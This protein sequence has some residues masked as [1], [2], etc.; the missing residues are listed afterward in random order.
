MRRYCTVAV[1]I[2]FALM[3]PAAAHAEVFT[4]A[5]PTE[6]ALADAVDAANDREGADTVLLNGYTIMLAEDHVNVIDELTLRGP[7]TLDGSG[8]ESD[9]I[10]EAWADLTIDDVR[11]VNNDD[12]R[13]LLVLAPADVRV[14]RSTFTGNDGAIGVY[15]SELTVAAR[16]AQQLA[17]GSLVVTD[18]TFE[19]NVEQYGGAIDIDPGQSTNV[20]VTVARSTF[21]G[22]R[23]VSEGDAARRRDQHL[24]RHARRRELDLLGQLRR[25]AE[26]R[27]RRRRDR[28]QR[29]R[30]GDAHPRH[31]HGQPRRV[32]RPRRRH[33]RPAVRRLRGAV[34]RA[35][36][37]GQLDRGRQHVR[38]H[39]GGALRRRAGGAGRRLRLRGR[40]AGRQPG[41]RHHL[42]LPRRDR[43]AERRP[44][45]RGAGRQ[46]RAD[47][48]ARARRRLA[49]R[50]HG[51]RR[52]MPVHRPARHGARRH[53]L[54][55]RRLRARA[56]GHAAVRAGGRG[57]RRGGAQR[58]PERPALQDPPAGAARRG[59][60]QGDREGQRQARE[61]EA[62]QAADRGRRPAR[63]HE[64]ALQGQH[65]A[66]PEGRRQGH[67]RPP[68]LDV[69]AGDPL[70]QAAE[71]LRIQF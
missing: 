60:A 66:A 26:L 52:P 70:D 31:D 40:H 1:A 20:Q 12:D 54:R 39:R 46:R 6:A 29:L 22:N 35:R 4:V 49:G 19:D 45:A 44:E 67:R 71:G 59:G 62:R 64:G 69:H 36:D 8:L 63:P 28:R 55:L 41:G 33:R 16:G 58:L 3:L 50:E 32:P 21:A 2:G 61:G 13:A 56:P 38:D 9:A 25:G 47:A 57:A 7:G 34:V 27:Q 11:L 53:R 5:A 18:T 30:L 37:G 14:E 65:H 24:A 15:P 68:L 43:Q 17:D 51:R 23:A 10:I 42:R 48:D